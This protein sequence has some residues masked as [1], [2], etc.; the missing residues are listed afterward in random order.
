[1][2]QRNKRITKDYWAADRTHMA[3]QRTL[4]SYIRTAFMLLGSGVTLIKF[5]DSGEFLYLIGWLLIPGSFVMLAI[6]IFLYKKVQ[7]HIK[8]LPEEEESTGE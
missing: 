3:N 7:N 4:L 8:N 1:M 2:A 6:G 5:L